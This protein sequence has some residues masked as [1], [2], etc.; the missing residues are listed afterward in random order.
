[1]AKDEKNVPETT[2]NNVPA[3]IDISGYALISAEDYSDVLE[4]NIGDTEINLFDLKTVKVPSGGGI[5]WEIPDPDAEGG[6]RSERYIDGIIM[7]IQDVRNYWSTGM[8]EEGAAG[9]PPDCF[10]YDTV[11]GYG[12]PGGSCANCE[13]SKFGSGKNGSQ[14]CKHN[15]L[16]MIMEEG[17]IL[18]TVIKAPPTSIAP[19]RKYMMELLNSASGRSGVI[20]RF[21]LTKNAAAAGKP[22]YSV[23]TMKNAGKVDPA[24]KP[25]IEK[26]KKSVKTFVEFIVK[27]AASKIASSEKDGDTY[28][29]AYTSSAPVDEKV[30]HASYFDAEPDGP[31]STEEPPVAE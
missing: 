8:D 25:A 13:F 1:M 16:V 14:A 11:T 20:T 19:I 7:H 26:A 17:S 22:A 28:D 15:R 3:L 4:E 23:I 18:P 21:S 12:N 9:S 6:S 10:S 31:I 30:S 5:A 29:A 24:Y 27:N 2:K